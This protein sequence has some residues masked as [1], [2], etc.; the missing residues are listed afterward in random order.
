ML[1]GYEGH[2]PGQQEMSQ[3]AGATSEA[4]TSPNKPAPDAAIPGQLDAGVTEDETGDDGA[5]G[6]AGGPDAGE[7]E[8]G[9][10][11]DAARLA[12][13]HV[14]LPLPAAD[15]SSLVLPDA[16]PLLSCAGTAV[17]GLC[18]HLGGYGASCDQT[19]DAGHGG[20]DSRTI[21]YTGEPREGGSLAN[22]QTVLFAL[23]VTTAPMGGYRP[24]GL[25][26]GCHVFNSGAS[27]WIDDRQDGPFDSGDS[28]FA[29]RRACA[30]VR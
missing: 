4:G 17:L 16:S 8:G 12:D 23:G 24:D 6:P 25:G 2:Q 19:C 22:C 7:H 27:Y 3:D 9:L 21:Y 20:F 1:V 14:P 26:L 11:D 10:S 18:W 5:I 28:Y 13:A 30:C 29:A 15:A